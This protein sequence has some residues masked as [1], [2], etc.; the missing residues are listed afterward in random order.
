MSYDSWL[1]DYDGWL[2]KQP[3]IDYTVDYD[4]EEKVYFVK[5]DGRVYYGESFSTEEDAENFIKW[6][7]GE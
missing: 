4:D 5:E 6:L 3:L 7:R 2:N 1:Q